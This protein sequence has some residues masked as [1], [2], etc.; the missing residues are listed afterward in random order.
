MLNIYYGRESIDKEKF[1]YESIG[2]TENTLVLVPDQYTLEA[3]KKAFHILNGECLMNMDVLS[4]SRLGGRVLQ[5]EGGDNKTFI[6]KYGR[7]M[8][9]S[10]VLS[11]M[12]GELQVFRGMERKNSFIEMVNNFISEMKQYN[13]TPEDLEELT[14]DGDGLHGADGILARKLSDLQ[15]IFAAYEEAIDGKFTDTE[16]Y[17]DLYKSRIS[18]AEFLK[19]SHIWIYGFDS[20]APKAISVIGEL[21]GAAEDVNVVLTGDSGSPDEE[22]FRL[23]HI[24]MAKLQAAAEEKGSD[25][26]RQQIPDEFAAEKKSAAV[27]EIERQLYAL[28]KKP[29]ADHG[30]L[31]LV[32]AANAYN[33]A[34]SAAS[35]I[36][37]LVRDCGLRYRDIVVIC[38]DVE[39]RGSIIGRVF[40]EYGISLFDDRKRAILNSPIAIYVI[41]LLESV[42]NGYRSSD[43][44]KVLKTG[45]T[46]LTDE[47]VEKLENYIYKYRIKGTMWKKPFLR[48][49]FEY[50]EEALAGIEKIR[51][52][53]MAPLLVLESLIRGAA[54]TP[55]ESTQSEPLTYEKFMAAFYSFLLDDVAL[56]S[57]IE[58]LIQ[59]QEELELIDL[60]DETRQ[61]W[62]SIIG[63]MDQIVEL[64]GEEAFNGENLIELLTIGLSQLQVGVLP[65][66]G[67]SV[68]LGTMQ[69]TR[70]ADVRAV[71]VLGA[72]EGILPT[73]APA[74]NLFTAAEL[75]SLA[76][77]GREICKVEKVRMLE[78]KLA[79]Y[80]NLSKPTDFLWLSYCTGDTEGNA[81]RPSEIIGELKRIFPELKV[82]RDVLNRDDML[83]LIGGEMS[84]LRHLADAI[85][86]KQKGENLPSGWSAV[87]DWYAD[88]HPDRL[89][90]MLSGFNF[91][92][93]Q[94]NLPVDLVRK[95]YG[96]PATL[97]GDAAD[98]LVGTAE[99]DIL[100]G[101]VSFDTHERADTPAGAVSFDSLAD[102]DTPAA[103]EAARP[104]D[105]PLEL[106]M[107]PSRMEAFSRCPFSHFISFGLRPE[108]RRVY[109]TGG[110]EI[111]DVYHA[112]I[113]KLSE[114]LTDEG[115]WHSV[116]KEECRKYVDEIVASE[117]A[118]YREGLFSFSNAEIYSTKR[119]AEEAFY[120]CWGI[121]EQVREGR[122]ESSLFEVPFGRGRRIPAIEI[123]CSL[124]GNADV[125][126]S[127]SDGGVRGRIFI[128]GKIDRVDY[129]ENG[130]V[131]IIDYKTGNEKF[132]L[133]EA[134]GGYRLQLMTYLKAAQQG[135]R[136]SE[137][138][139][140]A[141]VF[142]FL[143]D[144]P[145]SDLTGT[146]RE[147]FAEKIS[148]DLRKFF[149][150]NGIMV[151]DP[152]VIRSI[153]GDFGGN[154]D[155]VPLRK[156]KDGTIKGTGSDFLLNEDEFAQL[157]ADVDDQLKR[158]AD[159]LLGG[160]IEIKPKKTD[161]TSPCTYC[162]YRGICRFDVE[163]KGCNYEMI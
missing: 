9:L 137:G 100:A 117:T 86:R 11:E 84:T 149:K 97:S 115:T 83:E 150:L 141:G 23:S 87:M 66:S 161:K 106:K 5:S 132:D 17:I 63:L 95:L 120:A 159:E 121:V 134:R 58:E 27:K 157:Q 68:M 118:A 76:D 33:E 51:Q 73:G 154:S 8:L 38:N 136:A 107:S 130:R 26:T 24:V 158:I 21:I 108:E 18:Q 56:I 102:A 62:S 145:K 49:S 162:Q 1:I 80:R 19:K 25:W 125:T 153:A 42:V 31:T 40:A 89:Q 43:V 119:I 30:G 98:G 135:S 163:F 28:N 45:F 48:G 16:D 37:H 151:D 36:L 46:D 10:R 70:S 77:E 65:Q 15:R 99:S 79:V 93:E 131:K 74:Q 44:L 61:I 22:I 103:A 123:E 113:M 101:A 92:N 147:K 144:D 133:R 64:I 122:I 88:R 82:E 126:G 7:H 20:F 4:I 142:Y 29:C 109:E 12:S 53:A 55:G 129:L 104:S 52:K 71:L 127:R 59:T 143:I 81:V 72:N 90:N 78:E 69:R 155:I 91:T 3:E 124:N 139:E 110:R 148:S 50:G 138:R 13:V 14:G 32:E 85:H 105:G 39:T 47:E 6:D 67:D 35:F 57:K 128:E 94:E 54:G 60:A 116:E 75:E 160:R 156:N 111:G 140:P 2:G 152:D 114:R 146:G 34:E 112:C 41:A 96:R